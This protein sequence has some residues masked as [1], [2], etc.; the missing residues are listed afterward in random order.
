M[1]VEDDDTTSDGGA[2]AA[3]EGSETERESSGPEAT[4][5]TRE[6]TEQQTDP[7]EIASLKA[8]L[9]EANREA[10]KY[11][12]ERNEAK[13]SLDKAREA[14]L[15]D[16]EREKK[17]ADDAQA[18]LADTESRIR[19]ANLRVAL[20]NP[21]LKLVDV[22]TA[23]LLLE[24]Q[25]VEYDDEGEPQG[26]DKAVKALVKEKPFLVGASRPSTGGTNG[27]EGNEAGEGP[28]LTADELLIA[29]SFKMSPEDYAKYK[30]PITER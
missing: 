5:G 1:A 15:S 19:R 23:S 4:E 2:G 13:A 11:R 30:S 8:K 7:S 29:K 9:S 24:R 27:G 25:G 12:K 17:R 10:A 20:S 22:D 6:G 3:E 28:N 16:I 14:E 18:Q 26:I 21:E